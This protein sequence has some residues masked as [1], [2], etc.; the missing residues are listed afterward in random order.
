MKTED[1]QKYPAIDGKTRPY[2]N[3]DGCENSMGQNTRKEIPAKEG[4]R[5]DV[6]AILKLSDQEFALWFHPR[7]AVVARQ[8][9]D[10]KMISSIPDL[11][12]A[13]YDTKIGSLLIISDKVKRLE[14]AK[15]YLEQIKLKRDSFKK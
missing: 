6:L 5:P 7:M 12:V 4:I 14:E 10:W 1:F 13:A 8:L 15:E 2:E 9:E 3:V 11:S